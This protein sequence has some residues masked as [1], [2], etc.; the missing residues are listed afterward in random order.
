MPVQQNLN[1]IQMTVSKDEERRKV[2]SDC[3]ECRRPELRNALVSAIV[4]SSGQ[5]F[6]LDCDWKV[7]YIFSS[8]KM[9]NINEPVAIFTFAMSHGDLCTLDLSL[10]DMDMLLLALKE[11]QTRVPD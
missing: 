3:L 10:P 7:N 6:L 9:S 5:S 11:I 8:S 1:A 2:I 4:R